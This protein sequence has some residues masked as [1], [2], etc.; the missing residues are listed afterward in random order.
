MPRMDADRVKEIMNDQIKQL[1]ERLDSLETWKQSI[2]KEL[3]AQAD[4]SGRSRDYRSSRTP[5]PVRLR[6]ALLGNFVNTCPIERPDGEIILD[7]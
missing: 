7:R 3:Q 6:S 2:E 1:I 5:V 4:P